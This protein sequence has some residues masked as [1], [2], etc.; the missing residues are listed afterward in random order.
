MKYKKHDI[1]DY[2]DS[3]RISTGF[4]LDMDDKRLRILTD[5]GQETKISPNRVLNAVP[6]GD[7]PVT[8]R[9]DDQV[10]RLK[11]FWERREDLKSAVDLHELWEVV[12][13]ETSEIQAEDLSELAFGRDGDMHS[14]ASILRAIME[15]RIY[16]KMK[17]DFIEVYSPERVQQ[18]LAQIE[19][20]KERSNFV[21]N[22]A[23]FL[24]ECKSGESV[25]SD[26]APEG[27][28]PMLEQ[29][30][31]F[32]REMVGGKTLR[33]VLARIGGG[34]DADP[35]NL[36]VKMGAWNVDENIRLKAERVP[37]E[38]E[39]D[40]VRQA[41]EA[42]LRAPHE[43]QEDL[44]HLRTVAI[45]SETTRDVDDAL[46]LY[47]DGQDLVVGVH[48]TN[49]AHIIDQDSPLDLHIRQRATS[50]YLPEMTIPMI[51][52]VLS[53]GAASLAPEQTGPAIT[54]EVRF[55]PDLAMKS[56]RIFESQIRLT[57]RASYEQADERIAS[58]GSMEAEMFRIAE[59]L[60]KG[61]LAGGA[62]IFKDP[63]LYVRVDQSGEI[64][65]SLRDR[66]TPSQVL[67][68]E[69]MILANTL[70]ARFLAENKLPGIFRSQPPP[71]EPIKIGEGY[72]P[73]LSYRARKS[74]ARGDLGA[75]P[76]LHSTLGV[77]C[78]A[79]ATSPLRRYPDLLIQRQLSHYLNHGK[80]LLDTERIERILM[81]ISYPLERAATM[82]RER[83]RYF[84]LKYLSERKGQE[85]E[86]V[87]LHR[88][89]RF[90]LVQMTDFRLNA[91]LSSPNGL[92]LNPYDR[93]VAR[94]EKVNPRE[95]RV[96]LSL[97]R[98]LRDHV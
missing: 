80:P 75:S 89:P 60:R 9:K 56:F 57:E 98:L 28:I 26:D 20:E 29:A 40:T 83:Q 7:F 87:V 74:L 90:H 24:V 41:E 22:C 91:A 16:F 13:A 30:A 81:E 53:E 15:D 34:P 8:G 77:E 23:R 35:F 12:G 48:I 45:D 31:H 33:E 92:S 65:V 4:V 46:S 51:P 39:E 6:P 43:N 66:E 3:K 49:L 10:S 36:L 2:Y 54:A 19:K 5:R 79:T 86:S 93:V 25:N 73:V 55:G 68:S 52:P 96:G 63:E 42:A 84:M 64:Q 1:I 11:T 88:F 58:A 59:A 70:F 78:Y 69:M 32:G 71:L 14:V 50:I 27:L 18:S 37:V 17:P 38:F 97:V 82:E 76:A 61:R 94:V 72:D 21:E 85:F 62:I 67:V 47:T 44:S 95:D